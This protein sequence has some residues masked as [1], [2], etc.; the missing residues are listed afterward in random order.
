MGKFRSMGNERDGWGGNTMFL[1][2]KKYEIV[3]KK[4]KDFG[5][6]LNYQ[7]NISIKFSQDSLS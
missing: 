3:M 2:I 7:L 6:F 4:H 1:L 5:G